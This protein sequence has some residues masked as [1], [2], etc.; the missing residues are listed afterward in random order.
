MKSVL[1]VQLYGD[2]NDDYIQ[3]IFS[4]MH[5][6]IYSIISC[7]IISCGPSRLGLLNTPTASMLRSKTSPT[8]V[9]DMI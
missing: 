5:Y 8:S 2:D 4:I 3:Y 9:L 7:I 6:I 1:M